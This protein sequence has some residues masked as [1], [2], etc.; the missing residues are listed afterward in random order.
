[1]TGSAPDVLVLGRGAVGLASALALA[2][3]GARVCLIGEARPGEASLASAGMLAPSVEFAQAV[4]PAAV[5]TFAYAARDRFPEYVGE[6][7][8]QS[9]IDVP[10]NRPGILYVAL[11]ETA[12]T[13]I[14]SWAGGSPAA[15][16]V[17]DSALRELEPSLSHAAGAVL[18][19]QDGAVDT[20]VLLAAIQAVLAHDPNVVQVAATARDIS[21]TRGAVTCHTDRGEGFTACELVLAAGAWSPQLA[22]LPRRLPIE[23]VRGQ[24]LDFQSCPLRHV[25][26]GHSPDG[27]PGYLVPRATG[28]TIAGAT[29]ERVGFDPSTT[30]SG[31]QELRAIAVSLCPALGSAGVLQPGAGLRP[32]T[33]DLLPIVGR[34]PER[35]SLIYA[36]GHSRNGILLAPLTA[37]CVAAIA[38]ESDVPFDITPF[39]VARFDAAA[40]P[41]LANPLP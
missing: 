36:C 14:R 1:V 28:H 12:A 11:D 37:D 7:R 19:A 16:W 24:T 3:Q 21:F 13:A 5:R 18:F 35:P 31:R 8:E 2:R 25:V 9:G 17:D 40:P 20:L 38:T 10:L 39:R 34:D 33:P 32:V 26:Y 30:E 22:G 4:A 23:P 15:S 6:L 29:T 27:R 41:P